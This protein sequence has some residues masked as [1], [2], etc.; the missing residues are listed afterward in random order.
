[1][2]NMR[3][4]SC[5]IPSVAAALSLHIEKHATRNVM[6][7]FARSAGRYVNVLFLLHALLIFCSHTRS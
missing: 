2:D 4:F 5:L 6:I 1:M 7:D 3:P